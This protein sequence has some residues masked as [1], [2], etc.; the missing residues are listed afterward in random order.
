MRTGA[1]PLYCHPR[2]APILFA[3]LDAPAAPGLA[4]G[5]AAVDMAKEAPYWQNMLQS[6]YSYTAGRPD[7]FTALDTNTNYLK[8]CDGHKATNRPSLRI[9]VLL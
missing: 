6:L 4:S 8:A 7:C 5:L 1:G 9:R 2:S 3:S